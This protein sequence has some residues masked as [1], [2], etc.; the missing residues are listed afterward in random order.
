MKTALKVGIGITIAA[1]AGAIVF[2]STREAAAKDAAKDAFKVA[3]DCST[4]EVIDEARAKDALIA[5]AIA[6]LP[7]DD[8]KALDV[9]ERA[10]KV[11]WPDCELTLLT[12]FKARGQSVPWGLLMLAI[13]DRTIGQVK[14]DLES[15]KL[16]LPLKSGGADGDP[17]F[18]ADLLSWIFG[19]AA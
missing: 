19:G 3:P 12:V 4:I 14:A 13:G 5:T 10:F 6:L 11:L 7:S 18:A 16:E 9:A 15:G 1:V 2:L 17:P 8:E